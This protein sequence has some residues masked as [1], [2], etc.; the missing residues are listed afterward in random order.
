MTRWLMFP[1]CLLL[2]A[3]PARCPAGN[4]H[5]KL[6]LEVYRFE[7]EP[8]SL[9]PEVCWHPWPLTSPL[10]LPCYAPRV[11]YHVYHV[12]LHVGD[13][14]LPT[15]PYTP[16][17]TLCVGYGGYKSVGFGVSQ[18]APTGH[19]LVFMS[20]NACPGFL[21]GP[22]GAGEP[23]ACLASSTA[24]CHSEHDHEGY[25]AYLN[26]GSEPDAVYFNIVNSADLGH[27]KV[28]ACVSHYDE[29]TTIGGGAQVG[30]SQTVVCRQ[31]PVGELTWGK[32]K[33]LYR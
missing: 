11:P 10:D 24:I 28:V 32:L 23:A 33:G 16:S 31:M 21:K 14:N 9:P 20:W 13:L 29:G 6:Y 5:P 1:L 19:P 25:L 18:A 26:T 3:V 22:S 7:E 17:G 4:D 15:C 27:Y 8:A 12:P 30:G 2:L